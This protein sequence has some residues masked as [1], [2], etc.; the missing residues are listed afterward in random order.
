[1]KKTL[2][3]ICLIA[4]TAIMLPMFGQT[5]TCSNGTSQQTRTVSGYDY[6]LWSESGRGNASMTITGNNTNGG[7][8][9][10]EW[11]GTINVLS[12]SGKRWGSNSTATV[13]SVG[14][15]TIDFDAT[16]SS[17]DNVKMLG[18]YGWGYYPQG[19]QPSGFNT[20]IEYYII[21]DRGS[22][23][24]A[25]QGT[26]SR[27]RGEATIDGIVYEFWTAERIRQ[28]SISGNG[29]TFM[30]YFSVPKST[31]SHRTKGLITVSKHFEEWAKVGMPMNRLYEVALKVESYTGNTGNASGSATVRKNILTLGGTSNFTLTTAASPAAGGTVTRTPNAASY[32]PNTAVQVTAVPAQGWAFDSWSGAASGTN[33]TTSV[34]M[35]ANKDV[36]ANFKLV[37]TST[38]NILKDGN[39]PG[40]SLG[41]NWALQ[42]GGSSTATSSVSNGR[43]TINISAVGTN[44]WEPQ[45]VQ[46]EVPLDQGMKYRL[47]FTA[48]A[49][50]ARS[51]N[52]LLQK[53]SADYDTYASS[54]F[55]LTTTAQTYTLEF[56]MKNPSDPIAQLAFNLGGSTQNVTISNVQ[57]V[58]IAELTP[59]KVTL[60]LNSQGGSAVTPIE[61]NPG[62]AIGTLPTPT[63]TGYTFGG[64]F[65]AQTGGTQYT[66]TS[67]LSANATAYARWT[68]TSYTITYDSNGGSAVPNGTYTIESP[69]VTLPTATRTGY[70]FAGWEM[71]GSVDIVTVLPTGSIGNRSFT[72]KWDI[73]NYNIVYQL[74]D[75]N[76]HQS[77]P[78]TYTIEDHFVLMNP[79]K[80]G[81]I[82]DRWEEGGAIAMGS[83]GDKT[84]TAVWRSTVGISEFVSVAAL[85]IQPNPT[86]DGNFNIILTNSETATL[87]IL[88]MQ[89]QIVLNAVINKGVT[90][91]GSGLKTGV[92]IVTVQSENGLITDKLIVK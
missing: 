46:K 50:A 13:S 75:G 92:Y 68:A 58:H 91:I 74:D 70:N 15:I 78:V 32:A 8:F 51:I 37:G 79:A 77:N 60:T 24:A 80:D 49:V 31:S 83:T 41:S 45:L 7:T 86:M 55:N 2:I 66:A 82:F 44:A 56:E 81:F 90:S 87:S 6:E 57:L 67:T 12:R 5:L 33:A 23:N 47:T 42:A 25:S 35:N 21:Q 61:V 88:N 26:N 73:V 43:A 84:F 34:T 30:Q 36:T 48:S 39:F 85:Q 16:W 59:T 71:P 65:S 52:V 1:M 63:R 38:V 76:N 29:Q 22:Y 4:A 14:N 62:T 9:T 53:A 10:C 19:Q 54:D 18:V 27:K 89:G 20:E 69:A 28:A 17:S 64:W 40:N 72:A 3:T 11:S